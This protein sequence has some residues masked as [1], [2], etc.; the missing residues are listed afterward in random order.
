MSLYFNDTSTSMGLCQEVDKICGTN[1]TTYPL[2]DKA[3]R[4]NLALSCF[5]GI[6]MSSDNN[7][8]YDD[9]NNTDLP[10]G[11]TALVDEQNDYSLSTE[12]L[13]VLQ[14]ECKD[15]LG[16]I[17]KLKPIDRSEYDQPLEEIF[18]DS[19]IPQ[20]YDKVANSIILYPT[21]NYGLAGGLTVYFQRDAETVASTDTTKIIGIPSIFHEYIALK[22]SL[23]FL[24]DNGK[25][26][27]VAVRNDIDNYEVN[28]IP[29]YYSKRN[30]DERKRLTGKYVDYK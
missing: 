28:K 3:R 5:S 4:A 21:P 16:N 29:E 19:G 8:T 30:K 7:W 9:I 1:S 20:Y 12:I 13:K 18:K 15:T 10:I 22:M 23:P 17:Y 24:R 2:P 26:N 27:Y 11:S 25:E 6:A 14:V